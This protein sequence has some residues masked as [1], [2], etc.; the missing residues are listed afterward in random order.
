MSALV[1]EQ[2]ANV[3]L[4][5]VGARYV[6]EV[7]RVAVEGRATSCA[8]TSPSAERTSGTDGRRPA[9]GRLGI[10]S[11][12]VYALLALALVLIYRS[13]A[14]S[15]SRRARWRCSRRSSAGSCSTAACRTGSRSSSRSV[16][17]FV[18]GVVIE[19]LVIHTVIA[20]AG[21][22]RRDGDDRAADPA[23]RRGRLDLEGRAADAREPVPDRPRS[24]SA[25]S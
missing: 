20:L 11:G 7:G 1:V 13:T 23:E 5:H 12:G 21:A 14:S 17:S 2:N 19:R 8:G 16:L 6:L 18:G 9:T 4:A 24:T 3:A 22:H 10:A 25:A 15:T